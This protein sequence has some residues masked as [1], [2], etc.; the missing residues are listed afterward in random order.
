MRAEGIALMIAINAILW[1]LIVAFLLW[2][3]A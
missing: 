1:A 3:L 2:L